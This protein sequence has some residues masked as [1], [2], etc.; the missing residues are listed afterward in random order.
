[1]KKVDDEKLLEMLAQRIPQ[2]QIAAHFGVAESYIT[3]R[4]KK[5]QAA[6]IEV[7]RVPASVLSVKGKLLDFRKRMEGCRDVSELI[8]IEDELREIMIEIVAFLRK[9]GM[10]TKLKKTWTELI[11]E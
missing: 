5:L 9:N 7:E 1:M 2:K 11:S 4:K 3:K 10:K 6:E 8:K